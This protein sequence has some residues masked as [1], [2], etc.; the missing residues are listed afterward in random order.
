MLPRAASAE[1]MSIGRCFGCGDVVE[2]YSSWLTLGQI[3]ETTLFF[4]GK[5]FQKDWLFI[6]LLLVELNQKS[7]KTSISIKSGLGRT[8]QHVRHVFPVPVLLLRPSNC[9][10]FQLQVRPRIFFVDSA[11]RGFQS[12]HFNDIYHQHPFGIVEWSCHLDAFIEFF[13]EVET[14][15]KKLFGLGSQPSFSINNSTCYPVDMIIT[16]LSTGIKNEARHYLRMFL[17]KGKTYPFLTIKTIKTHYNMFYLE[18]YITTIHSRN[19]T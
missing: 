10:C 16:L 14:T 15:R 12:H 7:L 4:V 9:C 11:F 13:Q 19:N 2:Q 18:K 17:R 6:S 8:R 5:L 3:D 1:N